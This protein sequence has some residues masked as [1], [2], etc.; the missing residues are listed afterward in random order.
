MRWRV[1]AWF[2]GAGWA[3]SSAAA[4]T[5][6]EDIA[7]ARQATV[8]SAA[9]QERECQGHFSVSGCVQSVRKAQRA[10]LARLHQQE[11]EIR[12]AQR[13]EAGQRRRDEIAHNADALTSR[14]HTASAPA[15]AASGA[16]RVRPNAPLLPPPHPSA[17]ATTA[18]SRRQAEAR[19]EQA[20]EQRQRDAQAH[21]A[22][23]EQRNAER[24]SQ[25][26]VA[27]PLPPPEAASA[28]R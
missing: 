16:P 28:T 15:A 14:G 9:A 24:Q 25:G 6:L 26:K 20:Y 18:Q 8:A 22:A 12:D 19:S 17:S 3:A 2:L 21:R 4:Q 27:P 13:L 10:A 11:L 5:T 23:V 7:A 1:V